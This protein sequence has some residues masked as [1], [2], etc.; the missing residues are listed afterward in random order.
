ML[1]HTFL[2]DDAG[3]PLGPGMPMGAPLREDGQSHYD[4]WQAILRRDPC[5][6]CGAA[7]SGTV[8]HIEPRSR[9]SRGIGSAHGWVNLTGACSRCNGAKRDTDLLLFL[10]RRQYGHTTCRRRIRIPR[11]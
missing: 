1:L 8:D 4:A 3:H 2:R 10:A 11:C 7:R 9:P 5:A 6:Y